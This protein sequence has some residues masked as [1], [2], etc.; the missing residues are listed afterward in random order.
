MNKFMD[1]FSRKFRKGGFYHFNKRGFLKSLVLFGI[2]F[3][4][5]SALVVLNII[6]VNVLDVLPFSMTLMFIMFMAEFYT[7]KHFRYKILANF[8]SICDR[9]VR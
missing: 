6:M 2:M 7:L 3:L 5:A 9:V 4:A 8:E 1:D